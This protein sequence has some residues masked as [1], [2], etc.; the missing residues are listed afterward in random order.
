M[1]RLTP[2]ISKVCDKLLSTGMCRFQM[3]DRESQ[4]GSQDAVEGLG[5]RACGGGVGS[6]WSKERGRI[7]SR[8]VRAPLSCSTATCDRP[9]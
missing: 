1:M 7:W 5:G 6:Q 2:K 4:S 3:L 9:L 8:Y